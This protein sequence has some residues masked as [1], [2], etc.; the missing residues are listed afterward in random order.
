MSE[1]VGGGDDDDEHEGIE[2]K[3]K[4]VCVQRQRTGG[5]LKARTLLLRPIKKLQ[6]RRDHNHNQQQQ[7]RQ[8][9]PPLPPSRPPYD[10][11][12]ATTRCHLCFM[13][14]AYRPS[15]NRSASTDGSKPPSY[16]DFLRSLLEKNDFYSPECNVHREAS[17]PF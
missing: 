16:H 17:S 11:D 5:C 14:S 7:Q 8:Q 6:A 13:P 9:Q 15:P 12:F 10:E 3:P 4:R 2:D 1:K